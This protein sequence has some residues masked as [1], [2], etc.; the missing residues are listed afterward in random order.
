[1]TKLQYYLL[2]TIL[3]N[4]D[5]KTLLSLKHDIKTN[6][7]YPNKYYQLLLKDI[8]LYIQSHKIK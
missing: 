5:I 3:Q 2:T 6:I 4:S 7:S 8:D 1:M